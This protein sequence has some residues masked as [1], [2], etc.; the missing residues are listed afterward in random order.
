MHWE[1]CIGKQALLTV[2]VPNESLDWL[3]SRAREPE[4]AQL[5]PYRDGELS[6]AGQEL[7]RAALRQV[8]EELRTELAAEILRTRRLPRDP[9]AR[10]QVLDHLVRLEWDAHPHT[11]TLADLQATL[12]LACEAGATIRTWG[13]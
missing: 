6:Q 5:D 8:E 12:D 10:R 9:S 13:D 11:S 3:Q 1:V 4:V 2:A 7:W